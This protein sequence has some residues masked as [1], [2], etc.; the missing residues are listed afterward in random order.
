MTNS[1]SED[2]VFIDS[3]G[4]G[5]YEAIPYVEQANRFV[6]TCRRCKANTEV[7]KIYSHMDKRMLELCTLDIYNYIAAVPSLVQKNGKIWT[8]NP[9]EAIHSKSNAWTSKYFCEKCNL[10][11]WHSGQSEY[12]GDKNGIFTGACDECGTAKS[13]KTLD[14]K[15]EMYAKLEKMKDEKQEAIRLKNAQS[16]QEYFDSFTSQLMENRKNRKKTRK[17]ITDEDVN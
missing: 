6:G 1:E 8:K 9:R 15:S 11:T 12:L 3:R 13:G 10:G 7:W 17:K 14:L 16:A 5:K 4:H 2:K